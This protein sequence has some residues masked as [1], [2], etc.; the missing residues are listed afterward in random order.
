MWLTLARDAAAGPD[1]KWIV[2][3][4]EEAFAQATAEER[5][6]GLT[7]LQRWMKQQR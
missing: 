5:A 3:A 1:D 2:Q 4:H 7:Y 6:M